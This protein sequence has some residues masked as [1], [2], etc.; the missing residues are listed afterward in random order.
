MKDIVLSP[1][2]L[3]LASL[4]FAIL[5]DEARQLITLLHAPYLSQP[6]HE[7]PIN[8][9]A[10]MAPNKWMRLFCAP[11]DLIAFAL[12]AVGLYYTWSVGMLV[13]NLFSTVS[14]AL[15]YV[16]IPQ[17]FLAISPS[18]DSSDKAK[19]R[20]ERY[21]AKRILVL[22]TAFAYRIGIWFLGLEPSQLWLLIVGYILLSIAFIRPEIEYRWIK[23]G[24][25]IEGSGDVPAVANED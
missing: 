9:E 1:A 20:R 22:V 3:C 7:K 16:G 17:I 5:A 18:F 23:L 4:L 8:R 14:I 19:T 2:T 13:V 24:Y 15:I 21:F 6:V 25:D 10:Y 11:F 12:L